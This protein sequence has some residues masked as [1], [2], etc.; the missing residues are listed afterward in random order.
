MLL[1]LFPHC[2]AAVPSEDALCVSQW[3]WLQGQL[4]LDAGLDACARCDALGTG[5]FCRQC[6]AAQQTA[7]LRACP[8]CKRQDVG[9]Y[10]PDCGAELANATLDALEAGTHDWEA[11]A[12]SLEPF[13]HGL[14]DAERAMF[15]GGLHG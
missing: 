13:L 11:W 15:N 5:R 9:P 1:K 3:Q 10:C 12:K 7:A 2:F 14:T 4:L 8:Q 6:G